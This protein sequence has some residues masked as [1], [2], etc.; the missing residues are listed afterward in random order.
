MA[1]S[2]DGTTCGAEPVSFLLAGRVT[3]NSCRTQ[4]WELLLSYQSR[5]IGNNLSYRLERY[6]LIHGDGSFETRVYVRDRS[7]ATEALVKGTYAKAATSTSESLM[8]IRRCS[9]TA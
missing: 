6:G 2:D 3:A 4:A 5:G 9:F 8:Y 1:T 7:G